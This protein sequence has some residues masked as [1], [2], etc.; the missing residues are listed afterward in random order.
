VQT[1]DFSPLTAPLDRPAV[2]SLRRESVAAKI[3]PTEFS[4]G[5]NL[6]VSFFGLVL[7]WIIIAAINFIPGATPG[8]LEDPVEAADVV[9][10]AFSLLFIFGIVYGIYRLRVRW[11]QYYRT[12]EFAAANAMTYAVSEAKPTW[13][14]LLFNAKV[15]APRAASV[16]T[17]TTAPVFEAGNYHY[18]SR[19]SD[20]KLTDATHW[21]YI[22]A[23]LG[24]PAP[25]IVLRSRSR[26]SAK[27]WA[28][29]AYSRNPALSLWPDADRR[30]IL[31]CPAG[32]EDDA[33]EIF[34]PELI[35][36]LNALGRSVDVEVS[37]SFLFVY[38]CKPFRFPRPGAVRD[39]F[40]VIS[41]AGL[42]LR[43]A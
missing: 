22:V 38:S 42:I 18:S 41:L 31:Y 9:L 27:R 25:A 12:R 10:G 34:T 20:G 17:A 1:F 23:D 4:D 39:V 15:E 36:A 43:V 11:G 6:G 26:R 30:F 35:G 37:G 40:A 2:E 21:G 5:F 16:F 3:V 29:G 14:C 8:F 13:D 33:R 19:R 32:A 7:T 28:A 24:R